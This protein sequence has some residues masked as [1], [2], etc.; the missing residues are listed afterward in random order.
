MTKHRAFTL[1][2]ILVVLAVVFL[3][4]A[5]LFP[6]F[7][8]AREN[9]RR[10]NCASNCQQFALALTQYSQ[11]HDE[12]FMPIRYDSDG[13]VTWTDML[14]PYVKNAQIFRCPS[15]AQSKKISYGLN[16]LV[17]LDLEEH[18]SAQPVKIAQFQSPAQTIMLGE[19]GTGD[20]LITPR[21]DTSKLLPPSEDI[22]D[23]EDARPIARHFGETTLAFLD[24]HVK[25][26]RLGDF[27]QG[28]QPRDKWFSP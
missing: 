8:R 26:M 4:A 25:P 17:F 27:Y 22:E 6:V 1:V 5:L 28:Q 3:L 19:T 23:A 12:S 14:T 24:G 7:G 21:P 16:Q 10:T 11:D 15:D 13:E 20:D 18:P 9:A 2:E